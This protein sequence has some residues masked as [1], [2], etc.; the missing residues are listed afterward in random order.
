MNLRQRETRVVRAGCN[1]RRRWV[2]LACS[3]VLVCASACAANPDTPA[4]S[5]A[6]S[7]Y[8]WKVPHWYKPYNAK[9]SIPIGVRYVRIQTLNGPSGVS[10][11]EIQVMGTQT[12]DAGK[13][14]NI[15]LDKHVTASEFV[16]SYTPKSAVDGDPSTSWHA[17][18]AA[19]ATITIDLG[20]RH[21]ATLFSTMNMF[22]NFGALAFPIVVG[23]LIVQTGQWN[24]V[25]PLFGVLYLAAAFCWWR[26]NPDGTVFDQIPAT[27]AR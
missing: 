17:G 26:L 23:A 12:G 20:G 7:L 2:F 6:P 27:D 25:L 21:V 16:N 22:G 10:W 4:P 24:L 8:K 15:A 11:R 18:T 3:V 1:T 9:T 5:E 19:P 14:S 13:V